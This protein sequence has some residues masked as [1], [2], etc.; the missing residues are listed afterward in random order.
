MNY[1]EHKAHT[2]VRKNAYYILVEVKSKEYVGELHE[3]GKIILKWS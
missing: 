3:H 1:V 2:N